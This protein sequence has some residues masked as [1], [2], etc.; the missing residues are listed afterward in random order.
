M[1]TYI[2]FLTQ[3]ARKDFRNIIFLVSCEFPATSHTN[4]HVEGCCSLVEKIGNT[5][6]SHWTVLL[7][8]IDIYI[9]YK[10]VHIN[11]VE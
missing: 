5:H 11:K 7:T 8:K 1:Q 2:G 6:D 3:G 4:G 10:I 9:K